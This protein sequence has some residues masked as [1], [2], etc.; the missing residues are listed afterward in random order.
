M[1]YDQTEGSPLVPVNALEICEY[2]KKYSPF[3]EAIRAGK[4]L[5][6]VCTCAIELRAV[7]RIVRN[8]SYGIQ[9]QSQMLNN[10]RGGH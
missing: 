9:A 7:E 8:M 2:C 5:G 3:T 10:G 1:S 4:A 6:V